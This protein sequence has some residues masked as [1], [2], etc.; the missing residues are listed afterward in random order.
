VI[1]PD[2][3]WVA[4]ESD[5]SGQRATYVQSFPVPGSKQTVSDG[6]GTHPVWS[7]D[8]TVLYYLGGGD[9]LIAARLTRTDESLAFTRRALFRV[10]PMRAL[11]G[12][13]TPFAPLA[14]GT[15]LF[16]VLSDSVPRRT[17][18]IGLNWAGQ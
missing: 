18:R 5:E 8:G 2:G 11:A 13:R 9:F 1:S 4:Y 15:F 16:N 14:D 17:M 3:K 7:P 12:V 10:P 6:R